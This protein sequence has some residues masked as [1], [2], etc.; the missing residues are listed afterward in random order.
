[1]VNIP[2]LSSKAIVSD[3]CQFKNLE[4]LFNLFIFRIHRKLYEKKMLLELKGMSM[5]L[6]SSEIILA[7]IIII[8][9]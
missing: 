6:P 1:M 2:V 4:G 9:L 3:P 7:D 8:E 5:P